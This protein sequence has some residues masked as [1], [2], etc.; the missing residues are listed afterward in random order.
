MAKT[1]T[2]NKTATVKAKASKSTAAKRKTKT[3]SAARS[4]ATVA[5]RKP[6]T[7]SRAT[8]A[9]RPTTQ[10]AV[11]ANPEA[12]L[13]FGADAM[14][15]LFS[16]SKGDAA[17]AKKHLVHMGQEGAAQL[18]KSADAASRSLNEMFSVGKENMDTCVTC[19][20][21]AVGATKSLGAE[22]FSYA[23]QSFSQNVELSKE[24]FGC[25]TL[26][27]M[28]DLQSKM[29]KVNLDSFFSESVKMSE[30]AFQCATEVSEPLNERISETADRL[31]KTLAEAA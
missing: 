10:A 19:G 31:S 24:L 12:L 30:L 7:A 14:L 26:N 3:V 29:M 27:D 2:K 21:I 22:W 8:T 11:V 28:F 18:A 13:Q 6:A 17:D 25:R 5:K 1:A 20:N 23:N 15:D 4:K 9:K 16:T